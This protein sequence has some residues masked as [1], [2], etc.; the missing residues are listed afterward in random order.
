MERRRKGEVQK[1]RE[2]DR[3]IGGYIKKTENTQKERGEERKTA[4]EVCWWGKKGDGGKRERKEEMGGLLEI[5]HRRLADLTRPQ[6]RD[7]V[8]YLHPP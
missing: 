8:V 1:K 3:D 6:T 4:R 5:K 2:R 7:M